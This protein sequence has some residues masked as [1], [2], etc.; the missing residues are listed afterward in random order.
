MPPFFQ[1]QDMYF[2]AFQVTKA[3]KSVEMVTFTTI[4]SFRNFFSSY[5]TRQK[6]REN[7]N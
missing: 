3:Q 5:L 2:Q 6:V 1:Y 4:L 7:S